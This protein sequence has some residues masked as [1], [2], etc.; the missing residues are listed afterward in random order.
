MHLGRRQTQTKSQERHTYLKKASDTVS[1][2]ISSAESKHYQSYSSVEM[3]RPLKIFSKSRPTPATNLKAAQGRPSSGWRHIVNTSGTQAKPHFIMP[4]LATARSAD[5]GMSATKAQ[6]AG[7]DDDFEASLSWLA[8]SCEEIQE[9]RKMVL[10]MKGLLQGAIDKQDFTAAARLREE[11]R[12]LRSMDPE[13]LISS[14][15]TQMQ[16]AV[17]DERYKEAAKYRDKLRIVKRFLPEYQLSGLWSVSKEAYFMFRAHGKVGAMQVTSTIGLIRI[18]YNG[19]TLT[20]IGSDGNFTFNVYVSQP[21]SDANVS[22]MNIRPER[23]PQKIYQM[24][25]GEG[26]INGMDFS[27]GGMFL[28][29]DGAIGFWWLATEEGGGGGREQAIAAAGGGR[30]RDSGKGRQAANELDSSKFFIFA[31]CQEKYTSEE[32]EQYKAKLDELFEMDVLANDTQ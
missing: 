28:V 8:R 27:T 14:L 22:M 31:K 25:R 7:G 18:S 12:E 21:V 20:A 9:L 6:W 19:D 1:R 15:S 30:A 23:K 10:D 2:H 5:S 24:F 3:L 29:V 4:C 16:L 32:L 13:V 11:V 26:S 17:K